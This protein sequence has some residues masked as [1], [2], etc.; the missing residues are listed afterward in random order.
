MKK[1][2]VDVNKDCKLSLFVFQNFPQIN[3]KT[4]QKMLRKKDVIVNRER[5]AKDVFLKKGDFLELYCP[6]GAVKYFS[7]VYEDDNIIVVNK[8][9]GIIV[10]SKDKTRS[11]EIALQD[12]VEKHLG[13]RVF[14]LHRID[15]NTSG[16][17]IFCKSAKV[18]GD[19]K[20]IMKSHA[21]EKV[22]LAEV[23]GRFDLKPAVHK[24][25]LTKDS[26]AHSVR[27]EKQ[28]FS[29][30]AMPIA[31]FVELVEA[32][33]ATSIVRVKISNGKTHQIRA[34][35]AFL[36]F[37]LVGD[38]KY[39]SKTTNKKFGTR[40]QR[41]IAESLVF[42]VKNPRYSYLN[43]LKIAVPEDEVKT[44]FAR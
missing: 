24:A 37:P 15:M 36:G 34:H 21:V 2:V 28:A 4:F 41:L 27:V 9:F 42:N 40:K 16:L 35:M 25:F 23:V 7:V 1:F 10:A 12:L 8:A 43:G 13:R 32:R 20:E 14:A 30:R 31:T 6:E 17:V 11:H 19:M 44:Y 26:R 33:E 3:Y 5:V 18:F 22:Y 29:E 39:G 38:N